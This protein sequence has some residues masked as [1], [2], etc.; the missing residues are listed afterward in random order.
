MNNKNLIIERSAEDI[1]SLTINRPEAG[2]AF[3][4]PLIKSLLDTLTRL[5][6]APPRLLVLQSSGKHFSAGADLK[7]MQKARNLSHEENLKDARQLANLIDQLYHFPVPTLALVQGAAYGGALGLIAAC[8]IAICAEKCPL[9]PERSPDWAD[10]SHYQP[11][12]Y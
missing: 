5:K 9:L 11:I 6:Q 4:D 8:D 1:V 7:W 3:D 12:R 2:N 10:P